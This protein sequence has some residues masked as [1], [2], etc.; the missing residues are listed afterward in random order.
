M[1]TQKNLKQLFKAFLKADK[2]LFKV[3]GCVR[4]QLIGEKP[5]DIDLVSN[6]LPLKIK[7]LVLS[8]KGWKALEVGE[9]YGIIFAVAPNGEEFEIASFRSDCGS[10]RKPQVQLGVSIE[11]D[12]QRR[13]FTINALFEDNSGNIVDLV[14]GIED[15]KSKIIRC[16]GQP[17]KRFSEDPLRRVR[18]IRFAVQK[19]FQIEENTFN[20]I[21]NDPTLDGVSKERI[22]AE[23]SKIQFGR[24]NQ[25]LKWINLTG[26]GHAMFGI[27]IPLENPTFDLSTLEEFFAWILKDQSSK[28]LNKLEVHL[29]LPSKIA[30]R[31]R[32]LIS[33][34]KDF[35]VRSTARKIQ[36]DS[37]F[38]KKL[39]FN[40]I[41]K[42]LGFE[43]KIDAQTL[44][45]QGFKGRELGLKLQEFD[46]KQL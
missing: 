2:Q 43:P 10:G 33:L 34:N 40:L 16:V 8:I 14:G 46:L 9:A 20:A 35:N 5:K 6:A 45:S 44:M 21:K 26:L 31:V 24:F 11:D 36:K 25:L 17:D 13:D 42:L 15:I 19:G 37:E 29:K 1:T 18:A 4:D 38:F 28:F 27:D 22:V 3:G 23:L 41:E 39:N 7:S 12:V 32:V 30:N